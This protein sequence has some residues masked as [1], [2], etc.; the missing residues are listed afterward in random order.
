L[1]PYLAGLIER[2]AVAGPGAD[3]I[4]VPAPDAPERVDALLRSAEPL[5]AVDRALSDER[6][7]LDL[8]RQL[9]AVSATVAEAAPRREPQPAGIAPLRSG[10]LPDRAGPRGGLWTSTALTGTVTPWSLFMQV[11]GE[12]NSFVGAATSW[13]LGPRPDV[14][15]LEITGARDWVT[16]LDRHPGPPDRDGRA[17]LD[18]AA[19]ADRYDAV[20]FTMTAALALQGTSYR[21]AD[22]APTAPLYL[23]V[24][25]TVWTRWSFT[26]VEPILP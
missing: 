8:G 23:D 7:R 11:G 5:R 21:T 25:S 13:R 15:V 26:T 14:T 20:H 12:S 6:G 19:V 18:W 22:G 2:N 24:E 9:W 4:L 3:P 10:N 17:V 1:V 16:A